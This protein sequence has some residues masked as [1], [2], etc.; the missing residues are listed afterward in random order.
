MFIMCFF[1]FCKQRALTPGSVNV[2]AMFIVQNTDT[3]YGKNNLVII[4]FF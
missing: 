3:L 1:R 2:N 4:F